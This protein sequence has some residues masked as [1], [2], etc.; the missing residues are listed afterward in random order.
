MPLSRQVEVLSLYLPACESARLKMRVYEK[1][2]TIRPPFSRLMSGR[3]PS[4]VRPPL[5]QGNGADSP[6][7]YWV[8]VPAF[9]EKPDLSWPFALARAS[10]SAKTRQQLV[11][12][13]AAD[14]SAENGG[15][16]SRR[17]RAHSGRGRPENRWSKPACGPVDETS[18]RLGQVERLDSCYLSTPQAVT[19]GT[20]FRLRR[21]SR[22]RPRVR[23][24]R[25][26]R[27]ESI[28]PPLRG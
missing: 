5:S 13:R 26:R 21:A 6:A 22:P 18:G 20:A 28:P 8:G 14:L 17:K 11:A 16:H 23:H 12:K 27:Q 9:G 15:G 7:R 2:R 10:T 24:S 19:P 1:I 3:P 25:R 4:S